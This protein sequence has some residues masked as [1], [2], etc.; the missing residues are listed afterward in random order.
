MFDPRP[1][2]SRTV[3]DLGEELNMN[4][5]I[6]IYITCMQ[7]EFHILCYTTSAQTS[8]HHAGTAYVS[9]HACKKLPG[10]M[11]IRQ[12]KVIEVKVTKGLQGSQGFLIASI[13]SFLAGGS[14]VGC[15]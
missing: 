5:A 4:M 10:E 3:N 11:S 8:A 15:K 12:G 7:I 9:S 2:G 6:Y 14:H 13:R 1:S